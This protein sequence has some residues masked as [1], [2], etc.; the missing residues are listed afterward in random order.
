M[1]CRGRGS[2]DCLVAKFGEFRRSGPEELKGCLLATG[3][4]VHAGCFHTGS[5]GCLR[6][7][8]VASLIRNI[9][10]WARVSNFLALCWADFLLL[11]ADNCKHL[12]TCYVRYG[13][14]VLQQNK[15]FGDQQQ[16][17]LATEKGVSV[18]S[19]V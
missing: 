10:F 14:H 6:P 13:K 4:E 7:L 11:L 17:K 9:R 15:L 12:I 16:R 8:H 3:A 5:D 1:P 2:S 18:K 19:M